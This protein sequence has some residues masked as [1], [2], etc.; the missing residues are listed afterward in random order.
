MASTS[1][2][3]GLTKTLALLLGVA[4]LGL[5][6]FA[7]WITLAPSGAKS[8][9]PAASSSASPSSGT[10]TASTARPSSAA[11]PG[12]V[13][14][15]SG[16]VRLSSAGMGRVTA[17]PVKLNERV[18][19]GQL[20]LVLDDKDAR[21]KLTAAE[22][23]VAAA[24]RERDAAPATAGREGLTRAEDLLYAAER[25]LTLARI[26]LDDASM[27][28]PPSSNL[29]NLRR[30]VTDAQDR[31]RQETTNLNNASRNS[32]TAPGRGDI[33]VINARADAM[34]ADQAWDRTRIRAP[35]AGSVLQINTRIGELLAASPELV[36]FTMG[37]MSRL[38]V[39]A[40]VDETEVSRVR[41]GGSVGVR[42]AA[43]PGQE[44][45]GKITEVAPLLAFPRINARSPRRPTDVEVM[46]VIIE[47]DSSNGLLPGMRVEAFFR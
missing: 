9:R 34:L 5:A 27:A 28:T 20:L 22:A 42:N 29:A 36:V 3:S 24:K 26:E 32:T 12:R 41:L 38:R 19:E 45:E 6:G 10:N 47:L 1:G 13:E 16:L 7:A 11:A 23:A 43:F 8:S 30:R 39:R 35:M 33:A 40:E 21:S 31:V 44:F 25:A 15:R 14:P 17:I 37:D 46:E 4:S 18:I 2:S